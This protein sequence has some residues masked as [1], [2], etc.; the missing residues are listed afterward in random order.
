MLSNELLY[1]MR[2][3]TFCDRFILILRTISGIINAQLG[4]GDFI[5]VFTSKR[6]EFDCILFP[7]CKCLVSY[8]FYHNIRFHRQ[9][10]DKARLCRVKRFDVSL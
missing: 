9:I 8:D 3:Y 4:Q 2:L 6:S 5:H 7:Y 1:F 10:K